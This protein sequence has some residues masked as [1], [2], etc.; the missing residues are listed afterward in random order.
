MQVTWHKATYKS[1]TSRYIRTFGAGKLDRDRGRAFLRCTHLRWFPRLRA[2]GLL[3]VNGPAQLRE[4]FVR[5]GTSPVTPHPPASPTQL[6]RPAIR[7]TR[8]AVW[9]CSRSTV[10]TG[11]CD[12][13]PNRTRYMVPMFVLGFSRPARSS[14]GG[15]AYSGQ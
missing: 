6:S 2:P 14:S 15:Q 10:H 13:R 8:R 5:P 4:A 11:S 3:S 9:K 12:C 1:V 7:E